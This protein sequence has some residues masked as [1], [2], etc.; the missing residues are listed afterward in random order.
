MFPGMDSGA[1]SGDLLVNSGGLKAK[2]GVFIA[3]SLGCDDSK[4]SILFPAETDS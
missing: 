1:I 4:E 2:F 3:G